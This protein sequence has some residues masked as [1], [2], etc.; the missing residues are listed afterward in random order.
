MLQ[1]IYVLNKEILK[2]NGPPKINVAWV[3]VDTGQPDIPTAMSSLKIAPFKLYIE[4]LDFFKFQKA[5][6]TLYIY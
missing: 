6:V 3:C 5:L 1:T 4:F 2:F